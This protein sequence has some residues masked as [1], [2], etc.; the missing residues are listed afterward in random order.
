MAPEQIQ[1]GFKVPQSKFFSLCR[2]NHDSIYFL[3]IICLTHKIEAISSLALNQFLKM[4]VCLQNIHLY[5]ID[6]QS[7]SLD[8][9]YKYTFKKKLTNM[10]Y[11][12]H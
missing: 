5:L 12:F 1:V 11:Y 8:F 10:L 2:A 7:S 3:F 9:Q 6:I 4:C